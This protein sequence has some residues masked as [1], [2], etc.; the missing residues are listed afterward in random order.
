MRQKTMYKKNT[1]KFYQMTHVFTYISNPIYS[2]AS[3][4]IKSARLIFRFHVHQPQEV[5]LSNC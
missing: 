2:Y 4:A 1:K 5:I 3:I